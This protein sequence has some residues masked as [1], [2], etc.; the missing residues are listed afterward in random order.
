MKVDPIVSAYAESLFRL[1]SAEGVTDRV[2]DEL[3]ELERLYQSNYELKEFINNPGVKAEGKK[4]A[5]AELL[6]GKL[7]RV[8]LNHMYLIID[9]ERGRLFPKIA[10]EYFRLASDAR[11]KISAEVITAQPI[12]DGALQKLGAELRKL[13]RKDV[14]MRTRVDESIIGGVVVKVGDKVLDG[15]VRNKLFQLKKQMTG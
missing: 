15:S 9:Q 6:G 4:D 14:H 11:A 1:A 12:S 8:T 5:L 3:H 13:T 7:S 10:E 2:E